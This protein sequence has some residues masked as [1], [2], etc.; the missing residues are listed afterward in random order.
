MPNERFTNSRIEKKKPKRKVRKRIKVLLLFILIAFIAVVSY[1]THLYLKADSAMNKSYEEDERESGKSDL[2][3][4]Y[5]DPKFDNVSI[6]IMGIDQS[7]KREMRYGDTS[8]TD[9]LI[10]ATLNRDDKSVKLLS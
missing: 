5:V 10:L 3:D 6:L 7:E 1:G 4:D 8:R 9:A 2:R